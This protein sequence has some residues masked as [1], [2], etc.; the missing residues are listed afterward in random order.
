MNLHILVRVSEQTGKI[1]VSI[2]KLSPCREYDGA[3]L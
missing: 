1:A 3:E 2:W